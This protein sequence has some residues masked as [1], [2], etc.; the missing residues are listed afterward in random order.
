KT[1]EGPDQETVAVM[2]RLLAYY[3]EMAPARRET[4]RQV[5][6]K[7][8]GQ[9]GP[10]KLPVE[11]S[12]DVAFNKPV[13]GRRTAIPSDD[14]EEEEQPEEY[15]PTGQSD[16]ARRKVENLCRARAGTEQGPVP[17]PNP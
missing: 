16:S 12:L 7:R 15:G 14:G 6:E 4:D 8:A 5:K 13:D 9:G 17:L 1:L 2:Y 3:G 10:G 11:C